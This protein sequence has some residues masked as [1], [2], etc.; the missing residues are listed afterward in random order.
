MFSAPGPCWPAA[1]LNSR[2]FMSSRPWKRRRRRFS[3]PPLKTCAAPTTST[4]WRR[5]RGR[6]GRTSCLHLFHCRRH[7]VVCHDPLSQPRSVVT[8]GRGGRRNL[9]GGR[10][11]D[12][13]RGAAFPAGS[14][15][16]GRTRRRLKPISENSNRETASTPPRNNTGADVAVASSGRF[17]YGS[18]RGH[19]SIAIFAVDHAQGTLTPVG[20]EP[21]Q[22]KT[23]RFFG[24]DPAANFLSA[25]HHL[26][27]QGRQPDKIIFGGG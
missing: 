18:N 23:P 3:L 9:G 25:A 13:R 15:G 21:T 24:L 20:W 12:R 27:R 5:W 11:F 17:V 4:P 16:G 26:G 19:D 6:I 8:S 7:P 2:L 10:Y 1:R 22:G 14:C